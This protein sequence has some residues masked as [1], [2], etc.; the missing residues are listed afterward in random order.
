MAEVNA[1]LPSPSQSAWVPAEDG[2]TDLSVGT[3]KRA[4]IDNLF[5]TQGKFPGIADQN[6]YYLAL[7]YTVRDRLLERWINSAE[8]Y[9]KQ[10]CR[11]VCYLSAEFLPGPR[12]ESNLLHLG[13]ERQVRQALAEL[14]LDLQGLIE[15]EAEPGLGSGGLGRL[16]GGID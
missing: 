4:I 13:I 15:Q 7:A 5:Y 8:T 3:L 16:A 10:D 2:R 12:L 11:M 6:D 14:G 1:T 9:R